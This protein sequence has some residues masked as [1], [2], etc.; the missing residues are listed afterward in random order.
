MLPVSNNMEFIIFP[1][2]SPVFIKILSAI[3]YTINLMLLLLITERK[4]LKSKNTYY[5]V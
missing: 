2:F 1:H 4:I 3:N 5:T